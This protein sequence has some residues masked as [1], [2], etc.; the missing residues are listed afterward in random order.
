MKKDIIVFDKD[1]TLI[2]FDAFWVSVSVAAVK[3]VLKKLN[4]QEVDINKILNAFGV[5]GGMT[6]IDGILCKGT[7]EEL[8]LAMYDVLK[9]YGCNESAET[10]VD[11]LINAY[12]NNAESG[13]VVPTCKDLQEVLLKLKS[14]GR[15]LVVVTTDNYEITYRCLEALGI[16]ELFDRVFADDGKT[17]VKPNPD[18][19]LE[20]LAAEG[21]PADRAVMVGDTMTDINF[22]RN[23][24]MNVISVGADEKGRQRLAPFADVVVSGVSYIFDALKE[25]E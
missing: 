13:E 12:T 4:K 14:E 20:Y 17:P 8:G 23:A 2:D 9:E 10:V 7:Y 19:I 5:K 21:I 25:L 3:D 11:M 15:R 18:C 16:K 22:A 24:G 6:D 1:G